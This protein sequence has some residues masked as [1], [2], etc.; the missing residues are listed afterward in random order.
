MNLHEFVERDA[1]GL[2]APVG[3][4]GVTLSGGERQRLAIARTLITGAP[5][6]LLDGSTSSLDGKNEQLMRDAINAVSADRT[7]LVVAHRLSTVIESGQILVIDGGKI[8]GR[9]T[10][11]ELLDSTA[12]YRELAEHQLLTRTAG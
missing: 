8:V 3:E 9:G 1:K 11:A 10:H 2:D 7:L 12:L 5:I 6:L 4:S